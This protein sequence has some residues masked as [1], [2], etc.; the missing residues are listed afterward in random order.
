MI[1]TLAGHHGAGK[2]TLGKRLAAEFFLDRYSS[3]DFMRE[4]AM[5]R[6]ISL[7]DL[8][9]EAETDGGKIDQEID[10][11]Q[12]ALGK[13]RDGFII[14]GRLAFHFIPHSVKIFLAVDSHEAARRIFEDEERSGLVESHVSID[15]AAENIDI[16]RKSEVDR[17]EKYYGLNIYDLSL[18]DLVLD[19]TGRSPE[20]VFQEAAEFVRAREGI[21]R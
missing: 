3:G 19:T 1:I 14:D 5:E 16:R 6:G 8:G 11:R 2:S 7:L 13:T 20:E 4:M 12:I 15:H 17:Y 9:R 10:D 21:S 18:Y